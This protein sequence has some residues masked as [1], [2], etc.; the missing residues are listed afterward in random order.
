MKKHLLMLFA[1][2]T[3]VSMSLNAQ[4]II[5]DDG[6]E[7]GIQDS[8]WTQEFVAGNTAWAVE[9]IADG[10]SYP[11]TVKQGT[12]R[13]YLRNTTGETQGYVTRLVS[14]VM[15]LR[16]SKVYQPELSFWYANPKWTADRDTLRVL[17]RTGAKSK[18]KQLAEYSTAS[19]NWQR[20]NIEL[21]EVNETYQIAFEGTDNLGRG[22]V[23]DSV[24]L[25]SAPECTVPHDIVVNNK[26]ANKVNIAWIASWDAEYFEMV[27]TKDTID[28][29]MLDEI[30]ADSLVFHGLIDGMQQNYDLTL[31]SGEFYLVYIRSI[32]ENETSNWSSELSKDG[33]YGFRVRITKQVPYAYHFE[34]PDSLKNSQRDPEWV[35]GNNTGALNPYINS[36]VTSATTLGYYSQN[37]SHSA[38][39]SGAAS[40]TTVIPPGK[41]VYLTTPALTDSTK[42]FFSLN[43]CQVHFWSTVYTYTGRTYARSLIVGVMTDPEDITTFVPVDTVSVWGNKTFQENIVDLGSYTG[44]G[45]YIAFVSDFDRQNLFYIDDVTI[46]YNKAVNKVTKITVNP[47]D[48]YADISWEGNAS[49]YNVLITNA[50][51]DPANPAAEAIVDQAVVSSNTYHCTVLEADHSWNRPYYV[52]VQAQGT[53]WSYRYPFVTI[54][55]K[56]SVPYTFDF[57]TASGRYKIGTGNTYYPTG[58]GIFGN[59][60]KYPSLSSSNVYRGSGCLSLNKI[61]GADAWVTL[62]MVDDL[63]GTQVKFFLAGENKTAGFLQAHASIGV[64]TNPMDINSYHKV[65][66]FTLNIT[67]YTMCYANF[68]NYTGPDGVIAIVW[69]DVYNMSKNTFNFIDEVRVEELSDCVPPSNATLNVEPYR[70]TLGWDASSADAW[71]V[72]V[73]TAA[74]TTSQKDKSFEEIKALAPVVIA[75]TVTWDNPA[76]NPSFDFEGL[77]PQCSYYLYF[78]TVCH[79]DA[80]WWTEM[81][82]TTPCPEYEFPFADNFE[83][84]TAN[85]TS[86]GCWQLQDYVGVGYPQIYQYSGNKQLYLYSYG[87][88]HRSLAMMPTVE[89]NLSDMLLSFETCSYS[90][91]SSVLYVGTMADI[92]DYSTF[93]P[94]DTIYNS[95]GVYQ[96]VR[97]K[98]ADYDLA[99]DNIV[100]TSGV[101]TL[102]QNSSVLIDNVE[103]KDPSCIDAYNIKLTRV[104]ASYVRFVWSGESPND[105]WGVK[106]L[107]GSTVIQDETIVTGKAFEIQGLT[108]STTYRFY[109][110]ALCGDSAWTSFDVTTSC[111]MLN[112]A[113]PNKETFESYPLDSHPN[114]WTVGSTGSS[115]SSIPYIY[116]HNGTKI[117]Y[118]Y[119]S[120][121]TSWAASPEIDCD[122]LTSI[123]VTFSSGASLSS[124]YCVLGVM[125][126]PSDLSTFVA[127]D[128]VAGRGSSAELV[129]TTFDLSEYAALIP[130]GAKYIGWRGR[131][132]KS[133]WVYL[134]NVSFSANLCPSTKPSYSDLTESGV[135]ISSGLRA[136]DTDWRVLV[137]TAFVDADS[138]LS[139]TYVVPDS[140]IVFNE[141]ASGRSQVV[142]GLEGNTKYYVATAAFCDSIT[143]K[144]STLSFYTPCTAVTPESLGTI[145]FSE[146][147]GYEVGRSGYLPC[148]IVG[149]K[150]PGSASYTPYVD[151]NSY[152]AHDGYNYLYIQDYVSGTSMYVGAYAIMPELDVDSISKYQVSFWGRGYASGNN[153]IIIGVITDPSDLNTFVA[154]DTV[155]FNGSEWNPYSVGFENYDGDF[156]GDMGKNIMFLSEFGVSNYA[157]ISEV[158]IEYIPKCRPISSF[159]VDSEEETSAYVSW[160]G[161]QDSY[162]LLV[163]ERVLEDSIKPYYDYLIDSVVNHSDHVLLENLKPTSNYYVYAQGICEDGD[164]TAI[165][166][167]YAHI[168]TLCPTTGGLPIPFYEDFER[169]EDGETA[170]GCW[171]FGNDG[172]AY[173]PVIQ[174]ISSTGNKAIELWTY[175]GGHPWAVMPL[176]EGSLEDLMLSFDARAYSSSYNGTLYVGTMSD[177]DDPATFVQLASFPQPDETV[178]R[179]DMVLADYTLAGNHLA[180]TSG[181]AGM[182]SYSSDVYLDNVELTFVSTCHAPKLKSLGT[183]ASTAEIQLIPSKPE[184]KLWEWAIIPDSIYSTIRD[185]ENYLDKTATHVPTDSTNIIITGLAPAASYYIFAR[186]MCGAEEGYSPWMKDPLKITTQFYFGEGYFFGFEKTEQWERSPYSASNSYYIHPALISNRDTLGEASTSYMYYPY[187]VENTSS[188]VYSYAGKGALNLYSAG[189]YYGGYVVFPALEEPHARS[190]SFK[191]RVGY[192]NANSYKPQ[193]SHQSVL[194]VGTV[195]RNGGFDTYRRLATVRLDSLRSAAAGKEDNDYLYRFYTLDLDSATVAT[196]RLVLHAPQQP[197]PVSYI[198]VDDVTMAEPK[199]ISLVSVDHISADGSKANVEWA[200]IGGP[201]N[202]YITTLN[203]EHQVDTVAAYTKLGTTSQVVDN[204]EQRTPYTAILE[205]FNAGDGTYV[206]TTSLDFRTVCLALEPD[207]QGEFVWD[208]ESSYDW[209]TNDVQESYLADT[210]YLKPACFNVGITYNTPLNGYQ[211]LVQRKGYSNIGPLGTYSDRHLETG[212]NDGTALRVYTTEQEYN[213]YIVLPELN[214]SFD[215]MMIEFYGRPFAN[216]DET[217]STE[218]NRGKIVDATYLGDDYG[219]AIVVGT[220]TDPH[221]FSTL[222]VIDTLT[223]RQTHLTSADN[224]DNDTTMLR[225]WELMQLPLSGAQGKFIVL[226]QPKHGLFYIDDLAVK[227]AGNTLFAPKGTGTSAI[228]DNSAVLSWS[229]YHPSLQSVVVVLNAAGDTEIARDTLVG[230]SYQVSGLEPGSSYQWVVY[231]I[232]G[233]RRSIPSLPAN[234]ATECVTITPAY[235]C[236]FELEDG[237]RVIDGQSV[238]TYRQSL[239]WTYSDAVQG[240]WKSATYDPYNQA[241]SDIYRFSRTD[242]FALAMRASYSSYSVASTYQPY[243]ALPA[244]D[245]TAFDT[246]QISFWMRPA[247]VNANTGK[248]VASYTGSSYSKSVIVGTMTDPTDASTFVPLDTLTYDGEIA[249][250]DFATAAN[251]YLYQR[252]KVDLAGATGPY[253]A[254]MTSFFEKGGNTQLTGDYVWIDD[255]AF[256]HRQECK[257]AFNLNADRVGAYDAVLSWETEEPAQAY[258]LQVSTDPY[259]GDEQAVVFEQEV[260]TNTYLVEGLQALTTYYWR[261]QVVCGDAKGESD[262]SRK[263][264]FTTF[265]SPYYLE[266]FTKNVNSEWTF[267]MTHA[268]IVVDS[269]AVLVNGNNSYGF[270]RTTNGN[271]LPTSHYAASGYMNDFHWMVT[272]NF[273]LPENDSVHLSMDLALTACNSSHMPTARPATDADMKDDYYFMIIVSEDGGATWK[274]K[275]ILAKWQNTNPEGRQLRDISATGQK[276]RYSLAA[277]AGKNVRIGLYREAR[278]S[279]ATGFA[280]HVDN[281]RLAYFDKRAETASAC[282]YEDIDIGDIHIS[283]DDIE[284]GIHIYPTC[285]YVTDEEA[286]AG[287]RDSVYAVEV[288]VFPT[289]ETLYTDTICQGDTYTS[290]DFINKDKA[291]IYRRKLQT[292]VHGC[293]SI[294]TLQL[295]M[296]PR[297]YAPDVIDTLCPGET[298]MWNGNVYNRAGL[299]RDTLLSA[300]GCDSIE[301]LVLSYHKQEDTLRIAERIKQDELPYS[302]ENPQYPYAPGQVPVYYAAGTPVGKYTNTVT[303][304]GTNGCPRVLVLVLFI[305]NSQGIDDIDAEGNGA[306][307]IFYR[308]NLYIILN[309]E[310][311][312]AEGKKV[313]DPRK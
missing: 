235:T 105:Q 55:S 106:V 206:T 153:Q 151:D 246:L 37:K 91:G 15:D 114:C 263:A 25:R 53:E 223:Y 56:R 211:W 109:I 126:D 161:Y 169:Y 166:K 68:E 185:I 108:A 141:M 248:V 258:I 230:T 21:P 295:G 170:P 301:T 279:S 165:S 12:K 31:E 264:F 107:K 255:I 104:I 300:A 277:Y 118:L 280:I 281:V 63:Q 251:N 142:N 157:Y 167:V 200:N 101:G 256:S 87:T 70:F 137:T 145:T 117:L 72:V 296:I 135:R 155:T 29:N 222:K 254:I 236:G 282:Q 147:Q 163:A 64:M 115:T 196:K 312:N 160:K 233:D 60:P 203:A 125:T 193:S 184:N 195:N 3:A 130:A 172:S 220:L 144:W 306:R 14:K 2:V 5:I 239:C 32:C 171:I 46:E 299:Y 188:A 293:D 286:K 162:R 58:M 150:T 242:S 305:E 270:N 79:G 33:P 140:I 177:P 44:R 77:N 152:S 54:A 74:L 127:L 35:W 90:S 4:T 110:R 132:G 102:K 49:S 81:T 24:K 8:T 313:G 18:W 19:A 99:Y 103:L 247:Y 6:F 136:T 146:K 213:S 30:P 65:A 158:S 93:V 143:S 57:E 231:Q 267:S 34:L 173:Y 124:E 128:S 244:M 121:C 66:D 257:D 52:Y 123:V 20:V 67:G 78:R 224:V 194:E 131:I 133:D 10:L 245:I 82:F 273:Y 225:Y 69:E 207:A 285:F 61:A 96:K 304:I 174:E 41:Y 181:L 183:T 199:G 71:E 309:D 284:P 289:P 111:E 218:S 134:D 307:K 119:Q 59:D 159:T 274:S 260:S 168:L 215:S 75:D 122:S 241:N 76:T 191:V 180:F 302:Y 291:G 116:N 237:W 48:T 7:N 249:T 112:P 129:T 13:A 297:A 17:Y 22:I 88:T 234:F 216:Y 192:L 80:A 198:F 221:D 43:Q 212:R 39:F 38:I 16:P 1:A 179:Y 92:R 226:F 308:D 36:K 252:M 229:V 250:T 40:A 240:A 45:D 95:N 28:P 253:V 89:G 288:E 86:A 272:P 154:V 283:G 11:S 261:V 176:V 73:S 156:L 175:S 287:K 219:H 269:T 94:F 42:A 208:F 190:F 62:P 120:S 186:T 178:T 139:P 266:E 290:P 259:F 238:N 243:V 84:Y 98:L 83:S 97:L 182:G 278:T 138:L 276:V 310:W 189:N 164:S 227:N 100:F 265:R 262:F 201:W 187:C 268:D 292:Q 228:T 202:L 23:L 205:S 209:E 26:G 271:G 85:S 27:V 311:Y 275:N 214:C 294:I 47:R 204:L 298:L 148:W 50:E 217:H 51:V 113:L 232:D 197:S 210:S 9:D 303:V 149:S